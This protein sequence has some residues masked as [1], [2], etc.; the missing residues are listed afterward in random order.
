MLIIYQLILTLAVLVALPLLPVILLVSP[1]RRANLF[2]RLGLVSHLD[3]PPKVSGR[4]CIWVHALSVGE[5]RSA[6]PLVER[7][8]KTPGVEVVFTA[9]TKTGFETARSLYWEADARET[10]GPGVLGIGYFPFDLWW[11]VAA[12]VFRIQPDRVCLVETDLWPWFLNRV[13]AWGIPV[14]LVNA[15]MSQRSSKGYRRLGFIGRLFFSRLSQV[16]VQTPLDGR[17]FQEVG[18]DRDTIFVAGNMKF[19][20]PVPQLDS[21]EREEMARNLGIGAGQKVLVA[22][23]THPGEEAI[24]FSA[25][26]RVLSQIPNAKLVLAPRDPG[27]SR[28]IAQLAQKNGLALSFHSQIQAGGEDGNSPVTLIDGFGILARAYA[29]CDL[30]FIGG[31]LVDQGGHNPLEAALFRKP[32][33]YGPHMSDFKEPHALLTQSHAARVVEN[34]I[35]LA[36]GVVDLFSDPTRTAEMGEAA[37]AVYQ[38]NQGALDRTLERIVPPWAG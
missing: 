37:F 8:V 4:C 10:G 27:R 34:E 2:H 32:V 21:A 28:E 14:S 29:F 9:S 1:K 7:L 35:D 20:Q 5:V 6:Q 11:A 16:L 38:A 33:I 36:H 13:D 17:R 24:I 23:S 15:R 30:A 19:D 31:S 18:V 3:L 22:G 12:V 26:K 25:W